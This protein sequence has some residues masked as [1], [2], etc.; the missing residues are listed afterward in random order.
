MRHEK[1]FPVAAPHPIRFQKC[2]RGIRIGK[3]PIRSAGRGF[4]GTIE[5][6]RVSLLAGKLGIFS[7][8]RNDKSASG[9]FDR[10][11]A[12]RR[13]LGDWESGN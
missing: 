11:A 8:K 1:V 12:L 13:G 10:R 3:A 7:K 9:I 4:S 6:E 5:K 2:P